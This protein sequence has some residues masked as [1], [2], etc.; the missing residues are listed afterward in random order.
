M[1]HN[2]LHADRILTRL[3]EGVAVLDSAGH[4]QVSNPA[5]LGLL[6]VSHLEDSTLTSLFASNGQLADV[7]RRALNG[8]DVVDVDV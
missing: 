1:S 4:V 7:V 2:P 8:E 5:F 6:G 3:N